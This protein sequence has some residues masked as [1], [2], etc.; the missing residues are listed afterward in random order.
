VTTCVTF[1]VFRLNFP[2]SVGADIVKDCYRNHI[3]AVAAKDPAYRWASP[4]EVRITTTEPYTSRHFSQGVGPI[5]KKAIIRFGE[6][7][8]WQE[9][10]GW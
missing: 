9:V 2:K 5:I 3:L 7:V 8:N 6:I 1:S 10:L 4:Y